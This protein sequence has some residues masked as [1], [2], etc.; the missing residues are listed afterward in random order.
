MSKDLL[1]SSSDAIIA[2]IKPVLAESSKN[3]DKSL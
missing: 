3:L 1:P 2:E